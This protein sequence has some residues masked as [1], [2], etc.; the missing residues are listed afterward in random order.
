VGQAFRLPIMA[1]VAAIT[2]SFAQIPVNPERYPQVPSLFERPQTKPGIACEVVQLKPDLNYS[3]RYQAG[4]VVSWSLKG[5][6]GKGNKF[7]VFTRVTPLNPDLPPVYFTQAIKLRALPSGV[8]DKLRIDGAY[9]FG[10]GEYAIGLVLLDKNDRTCR[11]QWQIK[12]KTQ[13]VH[14]IKS[15]QDPG[16]V[17]P[18]FTEPWDGTL[19]NASRGQPGR[20]TVLLHVAPLYFWT[21]KLHA[22]DQAMLLSSLLALL[23]QTSF[24]EVKLV[25]FNLDQQ[26]ELYHQERFDSQGWTKLVEAMH[27]LE[28]GTVSYK[29]L[30]NRTGHADLLASLIDE[31]LRADQPA[32]VVLFLGP[33]ARQSEK[34]RLAPAESD[35]AQPLFLYFE[36][37][38]YW[39]RGNEFPDI[40]DHLIRSASGK[41]FHIHSPREF[42]DALEKMEKLST[43]HRAVLNSAAGPKAGPGLH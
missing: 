6:E 21:N 23:K 34:L 18:A 25:A 35:A 24:T 1:A 10:E 39:R 38:P 20:L 43:Q 8:K 26:T 33:T 15:V 36:F 4:Y 37:K 42:V 16:S 13:G 19:P 31:E 27:K 3:F 29:V 11:K 17:A 5:Y 32:D 22:Y 30:Q 2:T 28:L 12:V 14:Q 9:F 41:V 40:L 7:A